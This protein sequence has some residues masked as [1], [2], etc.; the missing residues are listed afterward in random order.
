[1]P[2]YPSSSTSAITSSTSIRSS[3]AYSAKREAKRLQLLERDDGCSLIVVVESG[4]EPGQENRGVVHVNE[5]FAVAA[6]HE[7]RSPQ[8]AFLGL[9]REARQVLGKAR[10]ADTDNGRKPV[11]PD[12]ALEGHARQLLAGRFCETFGT[13][14]NAVIG[15]R[16]FHGKT[17]LIGF[18]VRDLETCGIAQVL[19][20]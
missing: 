6:G 15:P 18:G 5:H 10:T 13:G 20:A 16:I 4:E 14:G 19:G 2:R 11:R 8:V 3:S 7:F 1:M 12:Q 17:A 9:A